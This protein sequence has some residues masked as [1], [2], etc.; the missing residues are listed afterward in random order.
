MKIST[1]IF[2]ALAV[3]LC[4]SFVSNAQ[5]NWV[6]EYFFGEDGGKTAGGTP[7]YI[8]HTIKVT[9]KNSK[10]DAHI[11]SQGYQTSADIYADVIAESNKIR[12]YFRE[13]G[14]DQHTGQ[15]K[16]GDLLLTLQW[17]NINGIEKFLTYWGNFKPSLDANEKSGE[18]YFRFEPASTNKEKYAKSESWIKVRSDNGEFSVEVPIK[19]KYFYDKEGFWGNYKTNSF[20]LKEMHMLNSLIDDTLIS[21]E[22]Y[23]TK[24]AARNFFLESHRKGKEIVREIRRKEYTLYQYTKDADDYYLIRQYIS[25]KNH[26]YI[27]TA[28]SRKGKTVEIK[29]FLNSLEF[30][31]EKKQ[32][33]DSSVFPFS[34]FRSTP[35][36]IKTN[37]KLRKRN[38]KVSEDL[39]I[40]YKSPP[41]YTNSARMKNVVGFIQ[42][43]VEFSSDGYINEIG[44]LKSLPEEGLVRQAVFA[45][46]RLK[47]L[48]AKKGD[49][50]IN[51]KKAV[52]Y[53]FSVF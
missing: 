38:N 24:K 19:N 14:K 32:K 52:Y 5:T 6:G 31:P 39:V 50:Y 20:K 29:K 46:M 3:V 22:A 13:K 27:L 51:M 11:Y 25:S 37:A 26:F 43:A 2:N 36:K 34:R 10:L 21:F 30:N 33:V 1:K 41:G 18:V 45:A 44:V 40:L 16:K 12:F 7:I 42:V 8:A 23:E 35:I 53:N 28:A 49:K 9:E 15:Y 48:P 4:L 17:G 47:H